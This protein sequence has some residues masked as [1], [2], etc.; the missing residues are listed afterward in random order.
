M[1][2]ALLKT[3]LLF[4]LASSLTLL[5]A[6]LRAGQ[7]DLAALLVE[8][9]NNNPELAASQARWEQYQHR[10]PQA[11]SLEDPVL[12]FSF[13][14]Y[15]HD[16]LSRDEYAMTG[17]ELRLAQKFPFPG[18][19]SAK[20]D[21]ARE[22]AAWYEAV[23]RDSRY[24]VARNVKDAWYRLYYQEQA[25][26]VT[27]R[28]LELLDN[29]TRLTESRYETGVGLQQDVLKAQ[30][31][32][33][34]LMDRLL[35]LRQ[36]RTAAQAELNSLANRVSTTPLQGPAEIVPPPVDRSLEELQ[37]AARTQRP[38]NSAYR[39]MIDRSRAQ[40]RLA[41]IDYWPDLTLWA[42]WRFRDEDL[43]DKGTD[44]VSAGISFNLPVYREK[45]AAAVAEAGSALLTAQR[46]YDEFR[47]RVD[48]NLT[49]AYSRMEEA[50]DQSQLYR[51]G[52][53]PQAAQSFN[54]ALSAYQVGKVEFIS[55]L[56]ALMTLY[57][58][59]VDYQRAHTDYLR[60]L[61]R[62]EAESGVALTGPDLDGLQGGAADAAGNE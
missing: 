52:I 41:R 30:L 32:R 60:S 1:K 34:R 7:D 15:P 8:A 18:K 9:L 23:Y 43:M 47:N 54:A 10:V 49:E 17:D 13:S 31:E 36:Q 35:S 56:D 19:L 53:I 51:E 14:N 48:R 37:A 61:A 42:G 16:S 46:Q 11:A 50:R 12:S 5:P 4:A 2:S 38:I 55:L 24:Q 3:L 45:R 57:R 62:L 28:S 22:Q 20:T 25:I 26:E 33:S 29:V 44:F 21:V 58:F 40:Q 59:E 6:P 39:A 27:E